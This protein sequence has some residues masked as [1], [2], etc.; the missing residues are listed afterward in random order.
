MSTTTTQPTYW[1]S[2][3]VNFATGTDGDTV[4]MVFDFLCHGYG[5]HIIYTTAPDASVNM[6]ADDVEQDDITN[7]MY[8]VGR[9]MLEDDEPGERIR[10]P[11]A[12]SIITIY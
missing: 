3:S 9:R 10:I 7:D 8:V 12:G 4:R 2:T 1:M 11:L 6:Y 5:I